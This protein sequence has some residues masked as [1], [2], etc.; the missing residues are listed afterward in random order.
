MNVRLHCEGHRH[1]WPRLTVEL[2]A[3]GDGMVYAGLRFGTPYSDQA[4]SIGIE[5]SKAYRLEDAIW[6]RPRLRRLFGRG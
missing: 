4:A 3:F 2:W 6:R 1:G 5:L